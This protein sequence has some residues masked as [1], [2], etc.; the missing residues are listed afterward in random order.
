MK[1]DSLKNIAGIKIKTETAS[2][3]LIKL[4]KKHRNDAISDIKRDILS[5]DYVFICSFS[6]NCK[7]FEELVDLYKELIRSQLLNTLTI[8]SNPLKIQT[9]LL[10]TVI[11]LQKTD[12]NYYIFRLSKTDV[13]HVLKELRYQVHK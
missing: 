13:E 7:K 11:Y 6:G 8:G 2:A 3:E 12:F 1:I 4:I 9:D 5:Y 10:K